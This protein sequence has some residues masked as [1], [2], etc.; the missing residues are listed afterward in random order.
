ML[1]VLIIGCGNIAGGFDAT[2]RGTDTPFSHAGAYVAQ[3]DFALRC[4]V[5]PDEVRRAA[6]QRPS[7]TP[8]LEI[9]RLRR[10][11]LM[12]STFVPE[13]SS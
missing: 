13:E 8:S 10:R 6:F 1:D 11:A 9:P 12:R 7:R 2:R 5:D 4:C 3:G